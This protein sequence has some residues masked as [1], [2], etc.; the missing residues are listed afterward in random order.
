MLTGGGVLGAIGCAI[1][2][3]DE[4]SKTTFNLIK[5]Y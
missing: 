2:E 1:E 5:Y 3:L 4:Y